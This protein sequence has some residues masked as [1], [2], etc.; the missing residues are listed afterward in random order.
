MVSGA[1][2]A[3]AGLLVTL[4]VIVLAFVMERRERKRLQ[5]VVDSRRMDER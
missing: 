1:W 2:I 3:W 5:R 4:G